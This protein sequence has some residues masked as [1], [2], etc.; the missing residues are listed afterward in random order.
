MSIKNVLAATIAA[1]LLAAASQAALAF[2]NATRM[3]GNGYALE[4]QHG[5]TSARRRYEQVYGATF[6]AG[7]PYACRELRKRAR[8]T[9]NAYWRYAANR[10]RF[11]TYSY[12]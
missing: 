4:G 11:S 9:G 3:G 2:D 7:Y 10:C 1:G 12:H 6:E 8:L 5:S